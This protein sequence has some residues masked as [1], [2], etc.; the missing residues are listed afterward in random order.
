MPPKDVKGGC[1]CHII[2]G[3]KGKTRS[4]SQ[5]SWTTFC[6]AAR[7]RQDTVYINCESFL[8]ETTPVGSYHPA[9][10]RRYTNPDHLKRYENRRTSPRKR[11]PDAQ[12]ATAP[13]SKSLRSSM[14]P[15]LV[16]KEEKCFHCRKKDKYK[17]DKKNKEPLLTCET[18]NVEA[19]IKNAAK[20]RNDQ[21]VLLDIEGKNLK[22][23]EMRYHKTCYAA[24]IN[25]RQLKLI[26]D[27]KKES[28]STIHEKAFQQVASIVDKQVFK[29]NET[30]AMSHLLDV[31]VE[32]I[33]ENHDVSYTRCMY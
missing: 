14:A 19:N 13:P 30:V 4:F 7:I 33:R 10:Y 2:T 8:D 26:E 20:I 12:T 6:K 27:S 11:K 15:G 24:Y 1:L 5:T 18:D 25:N 3:A 29:Q 16:E 23:I 31:Y 28:S 17:K 21:R 22:A 32:Y 9:C